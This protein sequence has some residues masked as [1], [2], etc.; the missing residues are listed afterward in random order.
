MKSSF[1][2]GFLPFFA[3]AG[4]EALYKAQG[5]HKFRSISVWPVRRQYLLYLLKS[6]RAT[7]LD[8]RKGV[9]R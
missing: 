3:P 6:R 4:T 1:L 7:A 5:L 2:L 9:W 8:S